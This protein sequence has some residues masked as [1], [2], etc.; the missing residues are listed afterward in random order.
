MNLYKLISKDS[1]TIIQIK[2][3]LI[4]ICLFS[5]FFLWDIKISLIENVVISIREI[6]YLLILLILLNYKKF[7]NK[8]LFRVTLFFFIF[9]IYNFFAFEFNF[10]Y[11]DFNYNILSIFFVFLVILISIFNTQEIIKNINSI[12]II[13]I[14]I[15][16]IS[17]LFIH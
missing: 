10:D 3:Y 2:N 4:T 5:F 6:F 13:F 7:F 17:F 8:S 9:L 14:Y 16:I 1:L 15:L 11:L 12:T